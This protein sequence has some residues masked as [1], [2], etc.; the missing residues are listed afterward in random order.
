MSLVTPDFGLLVWMTLIFGIV[1][2]VLAKWGF[3][4]ITSSVRERA[5]RI[6][7]SI[8]AAKEAE[9][10]LKNLEARQSEMIEEAKRQQAKILKDAA[11]SGEAIIEKARTE[12]RE[13]AEKIL[14]HARSQI[15]AEKEKALGDIRSEVAMLSV[16][17]AEKVLR[18]ELSDETR[19][20][21]FL[22]SMV[23]EA[24]AKGQDHSKVS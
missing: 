21:S 9:A 3:P 22:S 20:G 5:E 23:D 24:L 16:S 13:E 19:D 1:F 12:A 2:F 8:K 14:E 10:S 7:A 4:M 17:I 15:A 6:N 18:K 11:A